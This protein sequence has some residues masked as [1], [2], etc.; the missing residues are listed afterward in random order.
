ML[1]DESFA[2]FF[3][4]AASNWSATVSSPFSE[5]LTVWDLVLFDVDLA[6]FLAGFAFAVVALFLFAFAF[7]LS[8]GIGRTGVLAEALD[9]AFASAALAAAGLMSRQANESG[10]G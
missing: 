8:S 5:E 3:S 6:P 1:S 7:S 2:V 4:A 9:W 10:V